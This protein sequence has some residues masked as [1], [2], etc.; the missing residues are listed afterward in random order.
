MEKFNK[1]FN[2]NDSITIGDG[3]MVLFSGPCAVESYE[4]CA[5]VAESLQKI[6]DRLDI[7]Y[8]FK[9]SFDKAN[10]TSVDSYRGLG[11][12]EGLRV[13]DNI[14]QEFGLPI[15]TDIHESQQAKPVSDVAQA[16]QIPAYLCRQTDLLVAAGETGKTV[17]IK[18]G[19]FMAPE[20]MQYAVNKV[21]STGNEKI[22]LTERGVSFGYH[23]LVVDM[24]ALPIMRQFAPVIFDVTHSVQQPGGMGGSSGGKKQFAPYLARAAGATGVDGFFIET[25]PTPSEAKS[26]GPNMIPL[27]KMEDFLTMAKQAFEL[28]QQAKNE[29]E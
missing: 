27:H 26:D 3:R 16:L 13:L 2:L 25:H 6:C 29:V 17:K 9:A 14:K 8:I 10:R 23:N 7:Q 22:C 5:K 21:K 15:V 4:V 12:E 18:R 1:G 24:R 19:Q 20:D 11:F 28:G